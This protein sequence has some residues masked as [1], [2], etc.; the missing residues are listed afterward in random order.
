MNNSCLLD[1][2]DMALSFTAATIN[3]ELSRLVQE[4]TIQHNIILYRTL[5]DK[6]NYQYALAANSSGIPENT[7]YL[8][9]TVLPQVQ[10]T[11]MGNEILLVLNFTGVD[12][13]FADKGGFGPIAQPQHYSMQGWRYGFAVT[14]NQA[15][16]SSNTGGTSPSVNGQ[17]QQFI[18]NQFNIEFL[19]LD[20][21]SS[22]LMSH[23]PGV[24]DCPAEMTQFMSFYFK[25]I[26]STQNPY[27]LGYSIKALPQS[28]FPESLPPALVPSSAGF[29]MYKDNGDARIS[30]LNFVMDTEGGHQ[31]YNGQPPAPDSNWFS[32]GD[33]AMGKLI[34]SHN[35]LVEALILKP[36]YNNLQQTVYKQIA[37]HVSVKAGNAYEQGRSKT[38]DGWNFI[39]SGIMQGNN[40]Y[41]NTFTVSVHNNNDTVLLS[42]EGK[43]HIYK[44]VS[45]N[46]FFC[47]AKAHATAD[48]AWSG[49]ITL[50][51]TNGKLETTTEFRKTGGQK[52]SGKNGCADAFGWIGKITGGILDVFT[53]WSDSGFFSQLLTDAFSVNIPGTGDLQLALGN[54]L[55]LAGSMTIL[56]SGTSYK[57]VAVNTDME[58]NLYLNLQ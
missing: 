27:I 12:A 46:D 45:H 29:A 1:N 32:A 20:F 51:V 33:P 54:F 2:Y 23:D 16:W 38:G 7:E 6:G 5:N 26:G 52:S 53:L 36:F 25:H 42:F 18:A 34:I 30:N 56:P 31:H 55:P 37:G 8:N 40:Q 35:C 49:N 13:F 21:V 39:I 24:T 44:H 3:N 57:A 15:S 48:M 11:G 47:K 22:N 19:F 10:I 58:G 41:A 28:R 4:G 9:A 50:S 17:L 43:I 14:L